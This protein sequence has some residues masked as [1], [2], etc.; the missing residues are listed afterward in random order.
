MYT[1]GSVWYPAWRSSSPS[2]VFVYSGSISGL[3]SLAFL[4]LVLSQ[5]LDSVADLV[6]AGAPALARLIRSLGNLCVCAAA[7]LTAAQVRA[8]NAPRALAIIF[9]LTAV[10]SLARLLRPLFPRDGRGG[11]H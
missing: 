1:A 4:T 6:R 2:Y 5:T 9:L 3:F 7:L 8:E 11:G 10:L